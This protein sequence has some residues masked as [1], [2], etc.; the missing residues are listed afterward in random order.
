MALNINS[1]IVSLNSQ[2]QLS[3]T[4]SALSTAMQRLSSGLRINSARDDAAGMAISERFTTQIRGSN[5][6]IRNAN[7]GIS[8]LQTAEGSLATITSNL[9]R[10]RELAVQAANATNSSSDRAALQQEV[11]QLAAEIERVGTSSQFNGLK[12]FDQT[13]ASMVGDTNLLAL[14]DALTGVGGWLENAESM[15]STYYGL[16]ADNADLNIDFTSFSDGASGV[17]AQV[18]TSDPLVL[19]VDEADFSPVVLPNG[20]TNPATYGDR[21]VAHEMVHAVMA[22][23]MNIG[24]L[25]LW[26]VEGAAEF[27]HGADERIAQV[28]TFDSDISAGDFAADLA[29]ADLDFSGTSQDIVTDYAA[30]YAA[31]RFLHQA[32]KDAGGEGLK[33]IMADLSSGQSLNAAI[34]ANTGGTYADASALLTAFQGAAGISFMTSTFNLTNTDTGAIGGLDVDGGPVKTASSVVSNIATRSGEDVLEGFNE[35]FEEILVAGNSRNVMSFQIGSNVGETITTNIGAMNLEAMGMTESLD[36]INRPTSTISAIDRAIDYVNSERAKIGAQMSRFE[37]T[38][39]SL[40]I[41]NENLSA[42]RSRIMDADF[43]Q[44]TA[45]LSRAQIL[46]QAGT[47]MVAQANAL[48]QGVLA[49]LR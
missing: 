15:I 30:G 43:A 36:I 26:F 6:A 34:N 20:G 13:Q 21:I 46:Q 32:V 4:Q 39:Q 42:S 12:V 25:P 9:Q 24:A 48:P 23:T 49:L 16:T 29:A 7:D 2:R 27:I 47:A 19:Q 45:A 11:T 37:S 38:V 33:D 44:E 10:I 35:S 41:T 22:A 14:K 8:L 28:D 40:Q 3:S 18:V 17:L 31:V 5:Q 1:N